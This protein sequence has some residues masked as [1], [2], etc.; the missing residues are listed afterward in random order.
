M[1]GDRDYTG[2]EWRKWFSGL[3]CGYHAKEEFSDIEKTRVSSSVLM[4]VIQSLEMQGD[5]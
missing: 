2:E 1:K 5:R 3:K 4:K